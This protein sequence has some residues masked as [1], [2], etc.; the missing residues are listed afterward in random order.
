MTKVLVI[1][2]PHFKCDNVHDTNLLHIRS[3]ET[4]KTT[5]PDFV[6]ILGDI[7]H[8]HD[9]A[10]VTTLIRAQKWLIE[11]SKLSKTYLLIGNHGRPNNKVSVGEV[12]FFYAMKN[13]PNLIIVDEPF[14]YNNESG[15]EFLC[16]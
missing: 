1:G 5:K 2:D 9:K 3:I 12:H 15:L 13:Y 14:F 6:V 11:V 4:I 10:E 7:L 8:T 16:G